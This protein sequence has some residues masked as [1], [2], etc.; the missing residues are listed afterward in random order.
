MSQTLVN[1]IPTGLTCCWSVLFF[2]SAWIA[3]FRQEVDRHLSQL[4]SSRSPALLEFSQHSLLTPRT[5][6]KA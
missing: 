3:I 2:V 4:L 1:G 6:T 5:E